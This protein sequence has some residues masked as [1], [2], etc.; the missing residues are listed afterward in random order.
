M[1]KAC[2]RQAI[3][4][5]L[6][7]RLRKQSFRRGEFVVRRDS[8]GE[9]SLLTMSQNAKGL[10]KASHFLFYPFAYE[11]RAFDAAG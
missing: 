8:A 11:S 5:V 1:Q 7:L 10:L 2:L 4:F 9:A 3:F 6:S